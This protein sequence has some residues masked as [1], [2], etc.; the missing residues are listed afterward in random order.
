MSGTATLTTKR[1]RLAM[2]TP[3][4]TR[5]KTTPNRVGV[6]VAARCAAVPLVISD[7][8]PAH[9]NS[10]SI[11]PRS[12]PCSYVLPDTFEVSLKFKLASDGRGSELDMATY[13]YG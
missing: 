3:A 5:A 12:E 11:A 1:S 2:A 13:R 7:P 10:R 8:S 9:H 6:V 4:A